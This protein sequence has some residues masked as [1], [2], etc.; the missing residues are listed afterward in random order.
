MTE[1]SP[2]QRF[3]KIPLSQGKYALVDAEDFE[4]LSQWKWHY[5]K[6]GYAAKGRHVSEKET[7]MHR[8]ILGAKTGQEVDHINMKPLDNRKINLRLCSSGRNKAN[9]IKSSSNTSGCKGVSLSKSKKNPYMA[10]ITVDKKQI[11]LG[12]FP[13]TKTAHAAYKKAAIKIHGEFA[14]WK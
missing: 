7:Y 11:Y 12:L 2:V 9:K 5:H 13:S 10:C 14:R 1:S 3:K 4:W 8:L 6:V